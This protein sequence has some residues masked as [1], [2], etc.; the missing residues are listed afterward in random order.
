MKF[1]LIL[2]P[3]V[4]L[5]LSIES[6]ADNIS[7]VEWITPSN[8]VCQSSGGKVDTLGCQAT[9][10]IAKNICTNSGG[11]LPTIDIL[12]SVITNCGGKIIVDIFSEDGEKNEKNLSYQSCYKDK[13]FSPAFYWSANR[14]YQLI[15]YVF[16]LQGVSGMG[17]GNINSHIRCIKNK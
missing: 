4:I 12:E 1:K 13:G 17:K 8:R 3:L 14:S 16:F 2:I 5:E 6:F 9:W 7:K 11:K 10:E 15:D